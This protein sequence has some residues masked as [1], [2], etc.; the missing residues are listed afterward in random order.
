MRLGKIRNDV[1]F[2]FAPDPAPQRSA[3][4][5]RSFVPDGSGQGAQVGTSHVLRVDEATRR[6]CLILV[7]LIG[8][9]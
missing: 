1:N 3:L 4:L 6:G 7:S 2:L 8:N 5:V 9:E